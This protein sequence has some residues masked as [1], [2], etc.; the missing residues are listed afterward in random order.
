MSYRDDIEFV[1]EDYKD[2]QGEPLDD[3]EPEE[4]INPQDDDIERY[5]NEQSESEREDMENE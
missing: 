1:D 3:D 4:D 5:H 2:L